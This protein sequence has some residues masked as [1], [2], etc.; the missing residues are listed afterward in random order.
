MTDMLR[1]GSGGP[2]LG[3]DSFD[4]VTSALSSVRAH[5]GMEIAYLSEFVDGRSVFRAV[6]APGLEDR[7]RVGDS[8]ALRDVYC[9]HILDGRLPE[10]IPDTAAVALAASMPITRSAPIGSHVSIPIRK[11]DGSPY[12]MFCCLSSQPNLSLNDRDLAVMRMF[13]DVVAREINGAI[14]EHLLRA[15]M[16]ARI[17]GALAP[18]GFDTVLQPIFELG[19]PVPSGFE[20]LC[21]FS[22]EPYRSPDLWFG[23]A[24]RLGRQVELELRVM[25]RALDLLEALP[26]EVYLSVN[27]SPDTVVQGDLFARLRGRDLGRIVLELTE[28]ATVSDYPALLTCLAPLRFEGMLLAIDDAGAGY[29]GL[30]HIVQIRPDIIKLDMTLTRDI[31]RDW[32]RRSLATALVHFAAE[33]R[34]VIVAEGIE[35]EAELDVLRALGVHR[36]QGYLLGRPEGLGV[37]QGWFNGSYPRVGHSASGWSPLAMR[38]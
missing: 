32:P 23:E 21:R 20:A 28:H 11:A 5:L 38:G 14:A 15:E 16:Q 22:A 4:V 33:T 9:Q 3:D 18:G 2:R 10:L 19:R 27:L 30:Q 31:D 37:A 26:G 36:G 29:S 17:D 24:A 8:H 7:V 13:S 25:D 12:G 1:L 6:D 35:T 34:A